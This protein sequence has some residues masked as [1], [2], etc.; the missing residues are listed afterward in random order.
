MYHN[1]DGNPWWTEWDHQAKTKKAKLTRAVPPLDLFQLTAE[2]EFLWNNGFPIMPRALLTHP[3]LPL[4]INVRTGALYSGRFFEIISDKSWISYRAFSH[5][6]N[7]GSAPI[8]E[9]IDNVPLFRSKLCV[10]Y[11]IQNRSKN[12]L[13][14]KIML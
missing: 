11:N 12:G 5:S 6:K 9:Q 14:F 4:N 3:T 1:V 8:S 10:S 13:G 7:R 2:E